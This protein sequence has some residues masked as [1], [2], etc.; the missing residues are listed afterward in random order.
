VRVRALIVF[1]RF[2]LV[3]WASV[4]ITALPL[5]H[6]HLPSVF[7]QPVGVPHT[8]FSGD[9]PGEYWAFN[10]TTT[11]NE[12]DL[13]VPASNSPELGFVASLEE[14]GKRKPWEQGDSVLVVRFAPPALLRSQPAPQPVIIDSI[15]R[16]SPHIHGLRAPPEPVSV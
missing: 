8:V 7:Q 3:G 10:H 16:W 2:L 1:S 4:W 9:L 6:T 14:D 11:P 12:S 5:F 13:S 15:N